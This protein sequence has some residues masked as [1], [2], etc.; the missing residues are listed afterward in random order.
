MSTLQRELVIR[1]Y[2]KEHRQWFDML[3]KEVFGPAQILRD[4][5]NEK[6]ASFSNLLSG[7][8][9]MVPMVWVNIGFFMRCR[10]ICV[11]LRI[12]FF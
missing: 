4:A 7:F 8:Y 2:R 1:F 5:R 12:G 6:S 10:R 3:V 11:T 9:D